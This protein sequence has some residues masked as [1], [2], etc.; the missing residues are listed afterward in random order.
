M[1][2]GWCSIL[3]WCRLWPK[4]R[5]L[6]NPFHLHV[7]KYCRSRI[8]TPVHSLIPTCGGTTTRY[9]RPQSIS[10]TRGSQYGLRIYIAWT[11]SCC[12]FLCRSRFFFTESKFF[13]HKILSSICYLMT[14][15]TLIATL[16]G[17]NNNGRQSLP[18]WLNHTMISFRPVPTGPSL[19][20]RNTSI[21]NPMLKLHRYIQHNKA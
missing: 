9:I 3:S 12:I 18:C 6:E 1:V 16:C 7:F 21:S 15:F 10:S 11:K 19:M 4:F 8:C 13:S 2:G 20:N 17:G 5:A 14:H